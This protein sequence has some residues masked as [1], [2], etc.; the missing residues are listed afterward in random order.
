M[1]TAVTTDALLS[2]PS[3]GDFAQATF[4]FEEEEEIQKA[5]EP[6]VEIRT[7]TFLTTERDREQTSISTLL[8]YCKIE[9]CLFEIKLTLKFKQR[10]SW[11]NGWIVIQNTDAINYLLG[12]VVKFS[13]S[14][15]MIMKM[16]Q[17]KVKKV[18]ISILHHYCMANFFFLVKRL[19]SAG[20]M[21]FSLV[22][23]YPFF[24]KISPSSYSSG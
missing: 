24:L 5:G 18:Q 14:K 2:L 8:L 13:H 16:A 20:R 12:Q 15:C 22:Q 19:C 4:G 10:S 1:S 23:A 21:Q 11:L 3:L 7:T 9:I 17:C 6:K